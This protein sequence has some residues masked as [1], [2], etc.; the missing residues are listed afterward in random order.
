[1]S[2]T[3][4]K[5][6]PVRSRRRGFSLIEMLVVL[7]ITAVLMG[8]ILVPISTSFNFT[9]RARRTVEVQD[10]ARYAVE[11]ISRELADATSVVMGPGDLFPF[12]YYKGGSPG[13]GEGVYVMGAGYVNAYDDRGNVDNFGGFP[14]QLPNAIIDIILPHDTLGLEGGSVREPLTPQYRTADD[15]KEHPIIVRYFVGLTRPYDYNPDTGKPYWRN[16]SIIWR[17]SSLLKVNSRENKYTLFRVEFDPYDPHFANW[18]QPAPGGFPRPRPDGKTGAALWVV[19]PDFFY[20]STVVDGRPYAY[21]WRRKSV[22]VMS[23]DTMDLAQFVL[24]DA[25]NRDSKYSDVRSMVSFSPTEV[26]ADAAEAVGDDSTPTTYRTQY[27]H[28]SG[29]QNNGAYPY[30]FILGDGGRNLPAN[31]TPHITVYRQDRDPVDPDVLTLTPVFDTAA[32]GTGQLQDPLVGTRV[33]AWNSAKGTIEFSLMPMKPFETTA[34]GETTVFAPLT[35]DPGLPANARITPRSEVVSVEE[36]DP[37]TG[38]RH[39]VTYAR[40]DSNDVVEVPA[41][42]A[43]RPG[44]PQQLPAPRTYIVTDDNKVLVGYPYPN[45]YNVLTSQPVPNGRRVRISYN[46]QNNDPDDVVRV[47]YYTM[48]LISVNLRARSFDPVRRDA[49]TATMTNKV[50]VRNMKR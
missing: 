47:D 32:V 2:I 5:T 10:N 36:V 44:Q 41:G 39:M 18:A 33:L 43:T 26:T 22:A 34:D 20:D 37:A 23:G 28:W 7:A 46:Y 38:K 40:S 45:E 1:M 29:I 17:N 6:N 35:S 27:G 9:N 25:R 15:G 42:I 48:E 16:N 3:T 19:N 12:M 24:A 49:I 31:M 8:L 21:W 13:S 14:W 4:T 30:T 11:M 50:R